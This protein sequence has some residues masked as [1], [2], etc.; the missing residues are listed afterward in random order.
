MP[1]HA[2]VKLSDK[3]E[4]AVQ[5]SAQ[6]PTMLIHKMSSGF[7]LSQA[8]C[9]V[10]KLGIADFI[11]SAHANSIGA[12]R[13]NKIRARCGYCDNI[14]VT[15]A[16]RCRP[17]RMPLPTPSCIWIW[18]EHDVDLSSYDPLSADGG[19]RQSFSLQ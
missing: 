12:G 18:V 3:D 6:S 10:A 11:G 9:A 1:L 13:S 7:I 4:S 15:I 8:L 5:E 17:R 2:R 19:Q 14:S 16:H